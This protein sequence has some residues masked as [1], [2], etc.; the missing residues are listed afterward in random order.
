MFP[1]AAAMAVKLKSN[2]NEIK[3][4]VKVNSRDMNERANSSDGSGDG[5]I[6]SGNNSDSGNKHVDLNLKAHYL[7]NN[8]YESGVA[9][10]PGSAMTRPKNHLGY[11]ELELELNLAVGAAAAYILFN[12]ANQPSNSNSSEGID[13]TS[14]DVTS[15]S[16]DHS[17]K[18]VTQEKEMEQ[19]QPK[20][21]RENMARL[22]RCFSAKAPLLASNTVRVMTIHYTSE[23]YL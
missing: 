15:T 22:K 12:D 9:G 20:V 13:P 11:I 10:I 6:N 23:T 7:A 8:R 1:P 16:S 4:H 2:S 21:L 5:S 18:E 14:S 3:S 17:E 19:L